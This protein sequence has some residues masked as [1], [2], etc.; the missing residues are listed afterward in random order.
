MLTRWVGFALVERAYHGQIILLKARFAEYVSL[1]YRH[2]HQMFGRVAMCFLPECDYPGIACFG[3]WLVL[4][5]S[6]TGLELMF[7]CCMI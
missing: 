2:R 7:S 4:L 5:Y 3:G 1:A 6:F